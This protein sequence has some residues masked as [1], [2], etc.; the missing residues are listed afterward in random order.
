MRYQFIQGQRQHFKV[1]A[2]CRVMQVSVSGYYA[3]RARPQCRRA[4]QDR[5]LLVHIKSVFEASGQ[6]YGSSFTR[7]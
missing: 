7:V 5:V 4:Q 6:T 2:L 3:W 1:A